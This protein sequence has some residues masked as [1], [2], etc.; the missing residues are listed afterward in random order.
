MCCTANLGFSNS[1]RLIAPLQPLDTL[2]LNGICA[3]LQVSLQDILELFGAVQ[4]HLED[5][6]VI[7]S[8]NLAFQ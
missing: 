8:F 4:I 5:H 1:L 3:P 2:N 6:Q 7:T